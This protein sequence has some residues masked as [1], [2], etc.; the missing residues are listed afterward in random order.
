MVLSVG[1]I[2]FK[3]ESLLLDLSIRFLI[4]PTKVLRFH[5]LRIGGR[6][7]R[8]SLTRLIIS[9]IEGSFTIPAEYS[10]C[11]QGGKSTSIQNGRVEL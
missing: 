4:L 6:E 9:Q 7:A 2:P 5:F 1:E 8:F 10:G 11:S 3:V